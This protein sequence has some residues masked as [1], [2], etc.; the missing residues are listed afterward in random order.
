MRD[1]YSTD[2]AT[3]GRL[4]RSSD[5]GYGPDLPSQAEYDMDPVA[6]MVFRRCPH[7]EAMTGYAWECADPACEGECARMRVAG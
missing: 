3:A 5:P 4:A 7:T 1:H 2:V 6:P